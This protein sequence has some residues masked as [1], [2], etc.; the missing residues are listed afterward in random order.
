MGFD[1]CQRSLRLLGQSLTCICQR[2]GIVRVALGKFARSGMEARLGSDFAEGVRLALRHY[3]RRLRSG[4]VPVGLPRFSSQ[5]RDAGAVTIEVPVGP[6]IEAA[7]ER[8]CRRQAA[9][10]EQLAAHAV[11]VYLA[12]LDRAEQ[13]S[14]EGSSISR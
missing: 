12:D 13:A 1:R 2:G 10:V 8:E 6:E 9:S 3:V 11:F 14:L 7:L 5:F 4:H